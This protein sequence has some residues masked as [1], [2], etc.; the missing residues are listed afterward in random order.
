[1]LIANFLFVWMKS[2]ILSWSSCTATS[3]VGTSDAH[4]EWYA[5]SVSLYCVLDKGLV[6]C[7]SPLL[8]LNPS[9]CFWEAVY[10]GDIPNLKKWHGA[11]P[12]LLPRPY[13]VVRRNRWSAHSLWLPK[14]EPLQNVDHC[15][16]PNYQQTRYT[17]HCHIFQNIFYHR[18]FRK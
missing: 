4:E 12:L 3:F 1:M 18:Y 13:P 5:P 7:F 15:H 9:N 17:K 16:R 14:H 10:N 2:R 6:W 11:G 8:E